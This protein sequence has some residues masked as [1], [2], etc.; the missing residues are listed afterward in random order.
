M[1]DTR[2]KNNLITLISIVAYVLIYF[3]LIYR[4]IPN[5]ASII[6]GVFIIGLTIAAYFMYGFQHC[7]LNKIR[8]KVILEVLISVIVYY[9]LIY[10]LGI[11]AG[12]LKNAYSSNILLI[13]KHS[14]IPLITVIT[15]EVFRYI[16]ISTNKDSKEFISYAT[17]AIILF[18]IAISFTAIN[19]SLSAIVIYLT[20]GIIPIIFKN[21]VLSYLTYQVGYHSCIIYVIPFCLYQYIAPY[22]PNLG[23][24]LYSILNIVL[25]TLVYIYADRMINN[26]LSE[27]KSKWSIIKIFV[28]DLP[29]IIICSIVIGLIS[30][31]FKYKL[32][33]V[34]TT[35]I[36]KVDRGDLVMIKEIKYEDYNEGDLIAYKLDNQIILDVI[37]KK[38]ID[39]ENQVRL[40]II[41]EYNKDEENTLEELKEDTMI[42]KYNNFRI[43]KIAYPTI[44]FT[45][46]IDGDFHEN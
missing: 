29:L 5:Y 34:N 15:L 30:G 25:P 17:M 36:S 19:N 46:T 22:I 45:E 10:V 28:I 44:W 26:S 16:F 23:N 6:S 43:S 41:K 9:I 32:V 42:G 35:K 18:D 7:G 40:Y 39:D 38:E 11:F 27:K 3:L 4:F 12:F 33:G 1:S 13:A 14:I 21:V 8:K 37:E 20:V 24:Y 31:I 2:K